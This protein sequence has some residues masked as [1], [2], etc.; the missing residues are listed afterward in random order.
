MKHDND[1]KSGRI[2]WI[3]VFGLQKAVIHYKI[4]G[5]SNLLPEIALAVRTGIPGGHAH[6]AVCLNTRGTFAKTESDILLKIIIPGRRFGKAQIQRAIRHVCIIDK[7]CVYLR[8][9]AQSGT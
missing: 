9:S 5:S 7:R 2:G 6:V 1:R 8:E 3:V 4:F